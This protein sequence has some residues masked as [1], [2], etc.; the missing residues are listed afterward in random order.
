M[1]EIGPQNAEVLPLVTLTVRVV[2]GSLVGDPQPTNSLTVNSVLAGRS[3]NRDR[4]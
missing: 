2:E 4:I 1:T 3:H